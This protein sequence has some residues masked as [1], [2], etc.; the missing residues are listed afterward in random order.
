MLLMERACLWSEVAPISPGLLGEGKPKEEEGEVGRGTLRKRTV[1]RMPEDTGWDQGTCL[2]WSE[3]SCCWALA[4][5]GRLSAPL[6][7]APAIATMPVKHL[8]P[9]PWLFPGFA[10]S[11]L[12][13]PVLDRPSMSYPQAFAECACDGGRSLPRSKTDVCGA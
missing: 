5:A 1:Q 8:G 4:P 9:L 7:A 11:I 6:T 10:P 2:Y 12:A 13:R 3:P